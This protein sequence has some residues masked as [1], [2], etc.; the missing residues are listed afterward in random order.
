MVWSSPAQAQESAIPAPSNLKDAV[1]TT[2]TTHPDV[3]SAWQNYL[4]SK[5]QTRQAVAGY[6]PTLDLTAA[7]GRENSDNTT[8]R[9]AGR[10]SYTLNR[11]ESGLA[12]SQMLFD[13]FETIYDV[14][15]ADAAEASTMQAFHQTSENTG[16]SAVEAYLESYKQSL[17]IQLIAQ[18]I[19]D[20]KEILEKAELKAKSGAGNEADVE[21]TKSRLSLAEANAAAIGGAARLAAAKYER[22][23]GHPP[24][25]LQEPKLPDL[26][27]PDDLQGLIAKALDEHP[28][29]R[30]AQLDMAASKATH[31]MNRAAFMPEV[32]FDIA[33]TN[34]GN[35]S[36]TRGYAQSVSAMLNMSYNLYN[37]GSDTAAYRESKQRIYQSQEAVALSQRNIKEAVV[38]AWESM[39]IAKQRLELLNKQVD[40][41]QKVVETYDKQF[42]LGRRSLLD[43]L[44][45][46]SELYTALSSQVNERFNYMT[47]VYRLWASMGSLRIKMNLADVDLA[48]Q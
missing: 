22:I 2:L 8:T 5:Q 19:E 13:G 18:N 21:Q 35:V 34:N 28:S 44:N 41:A 30:G 14:K 25:E 43:L 24:K 9:G 47:S 1:V 39:S 20:H 48:N 29:L 17:Q 4:A 40:A 46:K 31:K 37:G 36:G 16:L 33:A 7:Y 26:E 45:S 27:L 12:L 10:G 15:R 42:K 23:I 6:Y 3:R 32:T 11:G 38:V